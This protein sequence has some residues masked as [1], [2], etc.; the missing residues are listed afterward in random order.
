[1]NKHDRA[2][3]MRDSDVPMRD[4]EKEDSKEDAD[5]RSQ[6]QIQVEQNERFVGQARQI[7]HRLELM[8]GRLENVV[9]D[10]KAEAKDNEVLSLFPLLKRLDKSQV[11]I[12]NIFSVIRCELD[13]LEQLI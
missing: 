3:P 6:L 7:L 12:D 13:E 10:A 5:R 11:N 4:S 1:M 2:M 9:D 8:R